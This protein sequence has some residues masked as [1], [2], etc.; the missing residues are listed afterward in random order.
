MIFLYEKDETEFKSFGIGCLK[1]I[2]ACT[3]VE[4]LNGEYECEFTYPITGIHFKDI[5]NRRIV[6]V[7]PNMVDREQPFRIYNISKPIHGLITVKCEHI[8]Y[9]LTGITL[10][11]FEVEELTNTVDEANKEKY[12]IIGTF[13]KIQNEALIPHKFIIDVEGFSE[14]TFDDE[15]NHFKD[16]FKVESPRSIRSIFS[17]DDEDDKTVL[18]GTYKGEWYFDRFKAL[19]KK[20]RGKDTNFQVRYGKN[21]TDLTDEQTSDK[22][23]TGVYP[24]YFATSSNSTTSDEKVYQSVY[25][26]EKNSKGVQY[27]NKSQDNPYPKEFSKDFFSTTKKGNSMSTIKTK[28]VVICQDE[29]SDKKYF[30]HYYLST[31]D[32]NKDVIFVDVTPTSVKLEK[33]DGR[34]NPSPYATVDELKAAYPPTATLNTTTKNESILIDLNTNNGEK[35]SGLEED[36][37]F[38]NGIV[39]FNKTSQEAS[40]QRI[41]T[42]DL[43]SELEL[44]NNTDDGEVQ[45]VYQKVYVADKNK[46]GEKYEEANNSNPNPSNPYPEKFTMYWLSTEKDGYSYSPIKESTNKIIDGV[47][48]QF[49][50]ED[51]PQYYGH[52]YRFKLI[53]LD[54]DNLVGELEDL[55]SDFKETIKEKK[56]SICRYIDITPRDQNNKLK[57]PLPND[58]K[59]AYETLDE[60][61]E[62]FPPTNF[63][64]NQNDTSE[65]Y[66]DKVRAELVKKLLDYIKKEEIGPCN[67][68]STI[69]V[70]FINQYGDEEYEKIANLEKVQLGDRVT[71]IHEDLD[72]K[73]TLKVKETEYDPIAGRYKSIVLGEKKRTIKDTY[74]NRGESISNLTND[75]GFTKINNVKMTVE[76]RVR[77]ANLSENQKTELSEGHVNIDGALDASQNMLDAIVAQ[78]LVADNAVINNVL[79]AGNLIINARG[80]LRIEDGGSISLGSQE[81]EDNDHIKHKV[82]LFAVKEDGTCCALKFTSNITEF[83]EINEQ[84]GR[85]LANSIKDGLGAKT[86]ISEPSY[87]GLYFIPVINPYDGNYYIDDNGN[88]EKQLVTRFISADRGGNLGKVY[89]NAGESM[90]EYITNPGNIYAFDENGKPLFTREQIKNMK[91]TVFCAK[92]DGYYDISP[93]YIQHNPYVRFDKRDPG[94]D[95][96]Q[97]LIL[98][99]IYFN[100]YV[101]TNGKYG[102]PGVEYCWYINKEGLNYYKIDKD[103]N[104]NDHVYKKT[105]S[106]FDLIDYFVNEFTDAETY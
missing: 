23:Y 1:E 60:L 2:T 46:K 86:N 36:Y 30:G 39:Y 15:D 14:T 73:E 80:A 21:M 24:F 7:K 87:L 102:N 93:S 44:D 68:A 104:G 101:D 70:S 64:V 33:N 53:D 78:L 83:P 79:K 74:I 6:L 77:N 29:K 76:K 65:E 47:V 103:K 99:N 38:Q 55:I 50:D 69:K 13:K 19:F 89:Y 62:A 25:I 48:V 54:T 66:K 94:M 61:M 88:I 12:G 8:S 16:A 4:K 63:P 34:P 71:V 92:E 32:D 90:L 40:Y 11:P 105:L 81:Y 41:L 95:I 56:E 18:T 27:D 59:F 45:L 37:T 10:K 9:D 17:S 57:T 85:D 96:N 72:I 91:I 31:T 51:Y 3:V 28:Y 100:S 58:F 75:E 97:L 98:K 43:S 49:A 20:K 67:I 26:A 5:L 42:L 84:L 106:F 35:P 82:P 22:F 52:Y